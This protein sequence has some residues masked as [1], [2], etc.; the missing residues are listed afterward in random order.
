MTKIEKLYPNETIRECDSP[1]EKDLS[2]ERP[3]GWFVKEGTKDIIDTV[4]NMG[5][6]YKTPVVEVDLLDESTPIG[7]KY[8]LA[9]SLLKNQREFNA[10]EQSKGS[11]SKIKK[12]HSKSKPPAVEKV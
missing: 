2:I 7:K 1:R 5:V 12:V 4:T 8:K 6:I 9:M 10:K 3:D 11:K